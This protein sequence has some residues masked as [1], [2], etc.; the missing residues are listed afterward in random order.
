MNSSTSPNSEPVY[1][2]PKPV[3]PIGPKLYREQ[4]KILLKILDFSSQV[5]I[6]CE[7]QIN[8]YQD[9]C[10]EIFAVIGKKVRRWMHHEAFEYP[11]SLFYTLGVEF[12]NYTSRKDLGHIA[13]IMTMF[14]INWA[15]FLETQF[16]QTVD[17][18]AFLSGL[19]FSLNSIKEFRDTSPMLM[20]I[21]SGHEKLTNIESDDDIL[22]NL[23]AAASS[24]EKNATDNCVN[25]RKIAQSH[26]VG[27]TFRAIFQA[28][29]VTI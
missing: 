21:M 14:F 10:G 22:K 29:K 13:S 3:S 4:S 20:C 1:V 6:N 26:V 12:A 8:M 9:P 25:G 11:C 2:L 28:C 17:S 15:N 27:I 7:H 24:A 23:E 18:H 16:Q 5:W 19:E